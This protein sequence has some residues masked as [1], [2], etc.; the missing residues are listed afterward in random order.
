MTKDGWQLLSLAEDSVAAET[1]IPHNLVPQHPIKGTDA[2][3]SGMCHSSAKFQLIPNL[4]EQK[5]PLLTQEGTLRGM[6]FQAAPV[7]KPLGS[8]K[9]MCA[10]GHRVVFEEGASYILNLATGEVNC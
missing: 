1:V 3:R 8:V 10:S 6:T 7:A 2:S 9:R 4:G 5:L